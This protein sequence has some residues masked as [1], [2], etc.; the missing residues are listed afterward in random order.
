MEDWDGQMRKSRIIR[1][2][3]GGGELP[4]MHNGVK[5]YDRFYRE[6]VSWAVL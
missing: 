2:H 6:L 5:I 3:L 1:G 4:W